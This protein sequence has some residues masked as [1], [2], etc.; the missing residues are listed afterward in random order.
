MRYG[1]V[2]ARRGWLGPSDILNTLPADQIRRRAPDKTMK[3]TSSSEVYKCSLF[4]VTEDQAVDPKTGFEIKR[5]VV[6]HGGS[7]VM[8]AVDEKKRILLVR[9]YRLPAGKVSVGAAGRHASI[10]AKNRSR[11]PNAN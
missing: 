6:R 5:S 4:R 8:M 1:V 2:T 9:Q 7:A 10:P 11:P 3:I